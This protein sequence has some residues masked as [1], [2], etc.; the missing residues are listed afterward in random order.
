M[1]WSSTYLCSPNFE[2]TRWHAMCAIRV[3]LVVHVMRSRHDNLVNF[4]YG[5]KN[6]S[7]INFQMNN[8]KSRISPHFPE[9][10]GDCL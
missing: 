2:F 4:N 1:P 6:D 7:N 3:T 5:I 10:K 8:T 9:R